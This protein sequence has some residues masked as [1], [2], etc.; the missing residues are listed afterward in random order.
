[1]RMEAE[2]ACR[3]PAMQ[4]AGKW[5]RSVSPKPE[6]PRLEDGAMAPAERYVTLHPDR[7][8]HRWRP[9]PRTS[10]SRRPTRRTP[11]APPDPPPATASRKSR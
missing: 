5:F 9:P 7:A 8:T 11:L 3:P 6:P 2:D 4:R 1:M 10:P